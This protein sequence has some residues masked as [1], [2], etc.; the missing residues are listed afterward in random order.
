MGTEAVH[1][2]VA[3]GAGH[4]RRRVL[5]LPLP[6]QGHINPMFHL[7]S[8]LHARGFAVTVFHLQPAGVN[9]PDASLHPAFDFVPVPADGDGDGAGGD[10]L[11]AT[12][13]GILDVNRRCEAPFRERL[14]ALLE[15]AALPAA[16]T[17]RASSPTRTS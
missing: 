6:L 12:L 2:A 13:A 1:A 11:E 4:R 14:A 7:A 15:E 9:A 16:A 8:V 3:A 17:S 5:L 10:Y